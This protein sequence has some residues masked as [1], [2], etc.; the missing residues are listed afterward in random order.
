[1]KQTGMLPY[2]QQAIF[3]LASHRQ[4]IYPLLISLTD[5]VRV[6]STSRIPRLS[7]L[8]VKIL[9]IGIAKVWKQCAIYV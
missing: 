5:W 3:M 4:T 1:M 8:L 2:I 6:T 7:P 9:D